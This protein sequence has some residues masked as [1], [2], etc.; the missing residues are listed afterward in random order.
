MAITNFSNVA[1]Y[2]SSK[3]SG[4]SSSRLRDLQQSA[5]LKKQQEQIDA[6]K[7]QLSGS[8]SP[9]SGGGST[10]GT[11]GG[12]DYSLSS[13]QGGSAKEIRNAL[14]SQSNEAYAYQ[15][16]YESRLSELNKQLEA[17][18]LSN[19]QQID[20]ITGSFEQQLADARTA[21]DAQ[22]KSLNDLMLEQRNQ[23]EANFQLQQQ[24]LSAAQLAYQNQLA[25]TQN[26]SKAFVPSAEQTAAGVQAGDT[27]LSNNRQSS[28]LADLTKINY[29]PGKVGTMNP[30]AVSG[31]MLA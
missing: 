14:Q 10:S 23:Y 7:K 27:R 22:I 3:I 19:Q 6:L 11:S 5:D 13:A 28:S 12:V 25:L 2:S 16:D 1:R 29:Y 15:Q 17:L 30:N 24:Q 4:Y 18:K 26:L 9:S 21:A 8:S 20:A 31:L